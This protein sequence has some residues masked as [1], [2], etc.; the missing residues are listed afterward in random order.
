MIPTQLTVVKV[1][2]SIDIIGV[3]IIFR[4]WQPHV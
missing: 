2:N 3:F 4:E 1:V